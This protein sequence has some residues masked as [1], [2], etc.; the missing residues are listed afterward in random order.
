[1]ASRQLR[2]W[3]SLNAACTDYSGL[4]MQ[5]VAGIAV[6]AITKWFKPPPRPGR[7]IGSTERRGRPPQEQV[8]LAPDSSRGEVDEGSCVA[9]Y[10]LLIEQ[11][12][13]SSL[14]KRFGSAVMKRT[15]DIRF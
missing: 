15:D 8:D 13:G 3:H 2:D 6:N 9:A 7:P 12:G 1:M 4:N 10:N 11:K 14:D 5:K